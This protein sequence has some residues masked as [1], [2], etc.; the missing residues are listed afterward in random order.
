M[1]GDVLGRRALN[2][3]TLA[4][5][6]LLRRWDLPVAEAVQRLA[7]LNGQDPEPPYLGLWARLAGFRHHALTKALEDR[8]VVR[9]TLLRGTQHLVT[10]ADYLAWRPLLQPMLEQRRRGAFGRSTAGVD[11]AALAA[12]TRELLAERPLTRPELGRLLAERWPGQD[13]V[14][15][16]WS[17]QY[18]VPL[19]HP[20]PSGTWGKRGAIPCVLAESWLGR[21]LPAAASPAG[22]ITR[23]L[24]AFGP[25]SVWTSRPGPGSPGCA[26]RSSGSPRSCARSATSTAGGSTTCPT[27]PV[28]TPTPRRRCACCPRWTTSCSPTPTAPA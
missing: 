5:Q 13:P 25:A 27:P 8:E 6:L 15:L 23:H 17:A 24:A 20:P 7:G 9:S 14:S 16:A 26:S 3:A 12:A 18:L 2:R 22:M 11:T 28:P 19:V 1:A 21:P 4:R 10:A